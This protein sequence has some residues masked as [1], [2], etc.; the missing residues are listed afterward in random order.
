MAAVV[1]TQTLRPGSDAQ[2]L[3]RLGADGRVRGPRHGARP[4]GGG[5]QIWIFLALFAV[6]TTVFVLPAPTS[7]GNRPWRRRKQYLLRIDPDLWAEVEK[8]A[9]DELRSVNAQVEYILRDAV[10]RRRGGRAA[11]D[12]AAGGGPSGGPGLSRQELSGRRG[13][14]A[15]PP[16][17]SAAPVAFRVPIVL[18][19][20]IG[21]PACRCSAA[22]T[23]SRPSVWGSVSAF[24][25]AVGDARGGTAGTTT[26]HTHH[27]PMA[28]KG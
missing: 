9:A 22:T 11:G 18:D 14:R 3:A 28:Q 19:C 20:R 13:R 27:E 17:A 24:G 15:P 21:T 7:P 6:A 4:H 8:W 26:S 10:R 23:L 16:P 2:L 12:A 1:P 25:R 5:P